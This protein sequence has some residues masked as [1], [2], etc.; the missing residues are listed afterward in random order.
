M[1]IDQL[2]D[3]TVEVVADTPADAA[4]SRYVAPGFTPDKPAPARTGSAAMVAAMATGRGLGVAARHLATG[5]TGTGRAGWRYL[6]A[7]EISESYRDGKP[8]T[9]SEWEYVHA[10]RRKRWATAAAT[11]GGGILVNLVAAGALM[12]AGGLPAADAFTVLPA[13]ESAVA[14]AAVAG[15]GRRI[16]RARALEAA[17]LTD[18]LAAGPAPATNETLLEALAAIKVPEG[19]AVVSHEPN[20]D[21]TSVTTVNLPPN[22]TV[23]SLR[24]K[25]EE[26]AGALGRDTTMVDI[27]KAAHANQAAIWLSSTDPFEAPRP[28]PLLAGNAAVDAYR[29]GVSVAWNKRGEIILLP[30]TNSNILI[31]GMTR[32][33]KGVG[34]ANLAVG[35]SLDVRINL[36]I[37]A[38]KQNGEWDA[39]AKARVAS[40]YFKPDPKRLLAL[41]NALRADKNRREGIL[42][43]L[44]KSKM[45]VDTIE[46]LGGIELLVIDELATYTRPG[47]PL[48]DEILEALIELS[49]VAAGAGIL[50]VLITQYPE[51]AVIP[52]ALAMNCGTK[53]AMRVDNATQSNAI[54]GEGSSG[55]GRDASKFDPP[56]PGL[57]WLVNPFA[58]VT[59]LARSFD[60]DEDERGEITLLLERAVR[61][62]DKAGR[63]VG[64]WN[65]PIE[66]TLQQETGFSSAAGGP[67]HNGVPARMLHL[68][69]PQQAAA[70]E[71][72][73]DCVEV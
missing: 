69:D 9:E 19:A 54:L 43:K 22:F 34:A 24:G 39:Y 51:V 53:W 5:T 65:D 4:P 46:K 29:Y 60:L 55:S 42:G 28:S 71:A 50:M 23:T 72:V 49:A 59:D 30:I 41:L 2:P 56:R 13:G 15:Y 36:R 64:Q 67:E 32:S 11:V 63:L 21:G 47:R 44:G 48:R 16:N 8:S 68:L 33:G 40:T 6:R 31:A 45:T 27:R 10:I 25:L 52:Q 7:H 73:V 20:R 61:V 17:P 18:A 66:N 1:A 38:G 12:L 26:L 14:G 37:V 58:A 3:T 35:A 57:G 70:Y 62:R